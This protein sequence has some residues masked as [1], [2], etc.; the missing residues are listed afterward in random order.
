[1]EL[2][3]IQQ[4]LEQNIF[5]KTTANVVIAGGFILNKLLKQ[6]PNDIDFFFLEAKD[7][8]QFYEDLKSKFNFVKDFETNRLLRG[9][10]SYGD[11]R[12]NCDLVKRFYDTEQNIINN[13]DFT[14][15]CFAISKDKIAIGDSSPEDVKNKK[16]RIN[17][18][19]YPV[20]SLRRF[21]K[22]S[23]RGFVGDVENE[24]LEEIKKDLSNEEY[25]NGVDSEVVKN[26]LSRDIF[27]SEKRIKD[28]LGK[29]FFED[30]KHLATE[31]NCRNAFKECFEISPENFYGQKVVSY[32]DDN[33]WLVEVSLVAFGFCYMC[34]GSGVA[35]IPC[36]SHKACPC[37]KNK[38]IMNIQC[39]CYLGSYGAGISERLQSKII[40]RAEDNMRVVDKYEKEKSERYK[41][42]CWDGDSPALFIKRN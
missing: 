38:Q 30:H 1:M 40:S 34:S 33:R 2:Q 20:G 7:F 17:K 26:H 36:C 19:S 22:F 39:D 28:F 3:Q 15:S 6:T 9:S 4:E 21:Y 18:L 14:I 42:E 25:Y 11:G 31:K 35:Y 24:I 23:K 5:S 37:S 41:K 16:L 12:I 27:Y 29:D 8:T 32:E 13:F 10:I